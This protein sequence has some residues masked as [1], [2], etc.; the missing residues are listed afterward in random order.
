M[1]STFAR[2]K[3]EARAGESGSEMG[4]YRNT[5]PRP[6]NFGSPCAPQRVAIVTYACVVS[7]FGILCLLAGA[8]WGVK[9]YNEQLVECKAVRLNSF[10]LYYL[11]DCAFEGHYV[12][13]YSHSVCETACRVCGNIK[14]KQLTAVIIWFT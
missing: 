2:S 7:S 9:Y 10:L 12:R 8:V 1:S 14:K 3:A 13:K 11:R 6:S 5:A 4:T